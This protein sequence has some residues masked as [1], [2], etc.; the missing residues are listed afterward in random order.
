MRIYYF[1]ITYRCNSNCLFCAADHNSNN[2]V[3][4]MSIEEFKR[5]LDDNH[6]EKNDRIILNGGEPTVHKDFFSFLDI[7][8]AYGVKID[9]FS[10]GIRFQDQ[11]FTKRVL[12]YGNIHIRIPLFG[13]SAETHDFLTNCAGSFNAVTKGLDNICNRI[14]DSASL[15]V[16]MLLSRAT[17]SENEKIY[18]LVVS[19]WN[20]GKTTLSLNPLLISNSVISNKEL[21][22][23]TYYNM[24]DASQSLLMRACGKK[25]YLSVSL[26]PYCSF[27][28]E[29]L[30]FQYNPMLKK[31]EHDYFYAD[32][33]QSKEKL[34]KSINEDCSK[35]RYYGY[36]PGFPHSYLQ[37]FGTS[38]IKPFYK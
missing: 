30:F 6:V 33:L 15:E 31:R 20:T 7:A 32:P 1:N 14:S 19:R 5:A 28:N 25:P 8:H 11:I 26:V 21:F 12:E 18:E 4:E 24:M 23:D 35:C 16:K 3:R 17:I 9:L 10:N 38:E 36:C 34:D 29:E 22:I 2:D 37:Y 27:P 13:S